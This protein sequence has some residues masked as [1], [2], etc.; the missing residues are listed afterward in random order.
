MK[1]VT[2]RISADA[3]EAEKSVKGVAKE[4]KN[5]KKGLI[6]IFR[7]SS[8]AFCVSLSLHSNY[9]DILATNMQNQPNK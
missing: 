5:L 3:S 6:I 8:K 7:F 1:N 4:T 2:I 9:I